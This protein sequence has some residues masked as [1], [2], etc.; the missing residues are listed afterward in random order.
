MNWEVKKD[1]QIS[2][3]NGRGSNQ[4]LVWWCLDFGAA[5]WPESGAQIGAGLLMDSLTHPENFYCQVKCAQLLKDNYN[6]V[7]V[8]R[9]NLINLEVPNNTNYLGTWSIY[10]Y[11][12]SQHSVALS[13]SPITV[14][15]FLIPSW[16]Q[17]A[18]IFLSHLYSEDSKISFSFHQLFLAHR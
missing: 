14:G 3:H 4:V 11:T 1:P 2:I 8:M 7:T 13:S 10:I 15:I 18:F 16:C 12:H 17:Y 5:E 6:P 9:H